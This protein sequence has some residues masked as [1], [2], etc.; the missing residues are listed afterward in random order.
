M[1][2][3]IGIALL[4]ASW[5]LGL[6]FYEQA[7]PAAWFALV[8]AGTLLLAC[9]P[10]LAGAAAAGS[11]DDE[12]RPDM[13]VASPAWSAAH[14][15]AAAALLVPVV[16]LA[17]WPYG[18]GPACLLIG[19]LLWL[20]PLGQGWLQSL[21]SAAVTAGLVLVAQAGA[22]W[23]YIAATAQSHDAPWPLPQLLAGVVQLLGADATVEGPSVAMHTMRQTHRLA[24]TWD[25]LVDPATLCF[26][27]GGLTWLAWTAC[28]CLPAGE[29]HARVAAGRGHAGADDRRLAAAACRRAYS[30]LSAAGRAIPLRLAAA[31]DESLL[32]L[33]GQPFAVGRAGAIGLAA[34]AAA[35]FAGAG[36]AGGRG[37]LVR[38]WLCQCFLWN[39][40]S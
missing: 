5:L 6:N 15:L 13:P 37:C 31:H 17:R 12:M 18:V 32:L 11:P 9:T 29:R 24:A 35:R 3:W 1:Q 36:T 30:R 20:L 25:L 26:F 2:A 39:R 8:A 19:L 4:A 23:L 16:C 21:V 28:R 10:R 38:H 33:L 7:N 34:G 27:V 40:P 14:V 22:V